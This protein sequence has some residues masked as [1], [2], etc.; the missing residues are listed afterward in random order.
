MIYELKFLIWQQIQ[1][2]AVIFS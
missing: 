2:F 1:Y